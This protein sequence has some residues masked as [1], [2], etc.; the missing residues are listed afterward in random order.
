MLFRS[1]VNQE[2]LKKSEREWEFLEVDTLPIDKIESNYV[3]HIDVNCFAWSL[4]YNRWPDTFEDVSVFD[5][6][7]SKVIKDA[8]NGKCKI[9]LNYGFEGLGT[10]HRDSILHK[11]LLERLHFLLDRY[12]IAYKDF[13]YMDRDQ[14]SVV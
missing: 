12:K 2:Y 5:S 11:P 4:G 9:L 10:Y 7:S 6:I 3:Y 14:K 1:N 13:I 8:Q